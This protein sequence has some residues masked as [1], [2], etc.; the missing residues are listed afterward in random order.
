MLSAIQRGNLKM[1]DLAR[2]RI[3][4]F[5]EHFPREQF[6][7]AVNGSEQAII[8][9][10]T[11]LL[12]SGSWIRA[13]NLKS[14]DLESGARREKA[15]E[16]HRVTLDFINAHRDLVH[17]NTLRQ[18]L[19]SDNDAVRMALNQIHYGSL[20]LRRSKPIPKANSQS[21]TQDPQDIKEGIINFIF[22]HR[23]AV[24]DKIMQGVVYNLDSAISEALNQIHSHSL[25]RRQVSPPAVPL[26]HSYK[27]S[28]IN[29]TPVAR[30]FRTP[31]P[32]SKPQPMVEKRRDLYFTGISDEASLEDLWKAFKQR[33][34][35]RD[36][37]VPHK[38]DRL[39]RKFGFLKLFSSI[40]AEIFLNPS[41]PIFVKDRRIIL[42]WAKSDRKSGKSLNPNPMRSPISPKAPSAN[43]PFEESISRKDHPSCLVDLEGEGMKEWMERIRRSVRVEIE[44]DYSPDALGELLVVASYCQVE[45]L[46]LGPSV[47]IL[48]CIDEREKDDLDLSSSGLNIIS[49]RDVVIMDLI[50]PRETG[51]RLQG[52]PVCA[53]S[54]AILD[55]IVSR[56]G[57][58]L[59][60]GFSCIRNQHVFT[61]QLRIS[62]RIMREIS[63]SIEVKAFGHVFEVIVKE[64]SLPAGSVLHSVPS[65]DK[66]WQD[67]SEAT[68]HLSDDLAG[69]EDYSSTV[70]CH[71]E[72]SMNLYEPD[73]VNCVE[74]LSQ[75]S[76]DGSASAQGNLSMQ[77][78]DSDLCLEDPTFDELE[79]RQLRTQDWNLGANVEEAREDR[80]SASPSSPP[81]THTELANWKFR[82]DKSSEEESKTKGIQISVSTRSNE[83]SLVSPPVD[84]DPSLV[85][86]MQNLKI[87]RNGGRARNK[88]KKKLHFFDFKLKA[89]TRRRVPQCKTLPHLPGVHETSSVQAIW[90]LGE[91]LGLTNLVSKDQA[92]KLIAMRLL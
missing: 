59:S 4:F 52:L 38:R 7:D 69:G 76:I 83:S 70:D 45:V 48:S 15:E 66:S 21:R 29:P 5:A 73:P 50:L 43:S 46:K 37:A 68:G 35:V 17:P 81:I 36:I 85:K 88:N 23:K 30:A 18:D 87:K 71:E 75:S 10:K 90:N 14:K 57:S 39:N 41:N 60:R 91:K 32:R 63:E 6:L 9:I 84:E 33:G 74:I 26:A 22:A 51:L 16:L 65:Q 2:L 49:Q 92:L 77:D 54:D 13:N 40:D 80:V 82:E 12:N 3:R 62:T 31:P 86:F 53:Y 8:A 79:Y 44:G 72:V 1:L 34:R 56:W 42:D 64:E 24:S 61:P 11:D 47:F 89:P 27:E 78:S 25:S 19:D 58:L 55:K 20:R 28:L 67:A